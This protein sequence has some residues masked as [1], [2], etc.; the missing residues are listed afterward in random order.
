MRTQ[1][2]PLVSHH[3]SLT[4][5][6]VSVAGT[7]KSLLWA[8]ATSFSRGAQDGSRASDGSRLM[9]AGVGGMGYGSSFKVPLPFAMPVRFPELMSYDPTLVHSQVT[10]TVRDKGIHVSGTAQSSSYEEDGGC[11][12]LAVDRGLLGM[13]LR[14]HSLATRMAHHSSYPGVGHG[15]YGAAPPPATK[16]LPT[17]VDDFNWVDA[18][19][20]SRE[21]LRRYNSAAGPTFPQRY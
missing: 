9:P 16:P 6:H 11:L 3:E 1:N 17:R 20:V 10:K 5:S 13:S 15:S 8:P 14:R 2:R 19:P 4:M 18:D 7:G 12:S 21:Y